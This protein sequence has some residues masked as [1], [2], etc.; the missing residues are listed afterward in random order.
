MLELPSPCLV[1][2]VGPAGSG[3]TRWASEHFPGRVIGSDALRAVAGEGEDD[4]RA[5]VDA[6]ALLDDIVERRMR[7]RLTTLVDTLGNDAARRQRWRAMAAK[8]D[9]PCHAVVLATPAADI[10]RW[11]KTREKRVPD[12]VLR[13]Q[14][15]EFHIVA[16]SVRGE[17]FD[18][19]HEIT[20]D[21][22]PMQV[23]P[24]M[25]RL[26]VA[27]APRRRDDSE[28][29]ITFG[30]QIPQYTWPA[31]PAELAPHLRDLAGR[32]EAAGFEALYVMDHFRQIPTFGPPWLDMLESWTTLAHLAAC[33]ETIRLGTLVTGITHRSV[34]LLGKIV[35]TLDVLSGGRAICG[36]GIGW[37]ED[38]HRA[39]GWR[40]PPAT[41]RYALLEDAL[42][43][44]PMMWGPG[45]KPFDGRVLHVPDTSCYPRPL[46]ERIPIMVG[47]SGERRTLRLVAAGADACNLFGEPDVVRRKVAVLA[48]H[49]EA[50]GRDPATISVSHLSTALVGAEPSEVKRLV[51]ATRP[52]KVPAERH[53]RTVNAGTVEQHVAR[54]GRFVEAGVDHVVVSLADAADPESV[55]RYGS[56]IAAAR[57]AYG[58]ARG[59]G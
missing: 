24:S 25:T 13:S 30:L 47:G 58:G 8:H 1:V 48:G 18:G 9:V 31:G 27:A 59:D 4:L 16:D 57:A 56:V 12:A 54:V 14:L 22:E 49:C 55:D 39:Y 38:E 46:Q 2:L 17:P 23:T 28:R 35:A 21:V 3:K 40:F 19:V 6:F 34:P 29:R 51:E 10:R 53:A 36:L 52:A 37:Y 7:R 20:P 5:S 33:T 45:G 11:N 43:L 41:E 15:S 42:Q 50:I 26:T 32:A 44:L